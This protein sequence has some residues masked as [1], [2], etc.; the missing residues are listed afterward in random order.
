MPQEVSQND[1]SAA[2][3][4]LIVL[5]EHALA[6][7]EKRR[8]VAED[9][10][11]APVIPYAIAQMRMRV[12]PALTPGWPSDDPLHIALVGGTN[13]GKSTVVNVCLG[14]PAAGMHATARFSQHPEAYRPTVLGDQWLTAYPSRFAG[15]GRFRDARPPRQPDREI[16]SHGYRPALAVFDSTSGLTTPCALSGITAAVLWDT[17]DFSTDVAQAYLSAVLD[18]VALADVV[19]MT[20]TDESYA[21]ARGCALLSLIS[22]SGVQLYVV[23]NKLTANQ[24]LL[25][26][27][28]TKVDAHWRG[29]TP[30]LPAEQW[31]CLPLVLGD[32]PAQRLASLLARR[33]GVALR[34]AIAREAGRG[35]ALKYQGLRGAVDFL[36]RRLVDVLRL[37][38]AEVEMA[39]AWERTVR[40]IIQTECLEPY[41]NHYLHGQRYGEFN[42]TL[43]RVMELLEVPWIGPLIKRL[44]NVLRLP[45]RFVHALFQRLLGGSRMAPQRAPEQELVAELVTR[46]LVALKAEAQTLADTATH[47]AWAEVVHGLDSHAWHTQMVER[48]ETAYAAYRQDVEE[49]VQRRAAAISQAIAQ[50]PWL[51]NLLRG[52]NLVVDTAA[53]VLVLKSGGLDWSDAVVAPLIASLRRVLVEAGLESYLSRQEERLKQKQFEAMQGLV[54]IYLLQPVGALFV[55]EVQADEIAAAHRDFACVQAAALQVAQQKGSV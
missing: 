52:T 8:T 48:F 5:F 47:P 16:L 38:S 9:T 42:Y 21:D 18:V 50:R 12:Q 6:V 33:E 55:S 13:S 31:Y 43:V 2:C 4:R 39:N 40:R 46:A 32:T 20:V 24:E 45:F 23:A 37:L 7:E 3:E 51:L 54:T 17:P 26:D 27:M 15:Y 41:R 22:E 36:E 11:R 28:K 19:M 14:S 34:D 25:D 49:E 30:G 29:K 44:S 35:A 10:I 53:I 1:A